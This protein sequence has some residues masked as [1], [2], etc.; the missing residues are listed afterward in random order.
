MNFFVEELKIDFS[1]KINSDEDYIMKANFIEESIHI[2][3]H[4]GIYGSLAWAARKR[5]IKDWI[6]KLEHGM[7]H[8]MVLALDFSMPPF[9]HLFPH[10]FHVF[11]VSGHEI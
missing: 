5:K 6:S 2:S 10:V 8:A 1:G 7:K 3:G 4:K 11:R 9:V